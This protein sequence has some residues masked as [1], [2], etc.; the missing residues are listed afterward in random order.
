M[1]EKRASSVGALIIA[2]ALTLAGCKGDAGDDG[3]AGAAGTSCTV[4]Q[5]GNGTAT[6]SCADGTTATVA[7]GTNG[8][9]GLDG[10]SCTVKDNGNGTKTITCADGTTVTVADGAAGVSAAVASFHGGAA[11][12]SEGEFAPCAPGV[13]SGC[14]KRFVNA[15]VTGATADAAGVVTVQF[16]VSDKSGAPVA[17]IPSVGAAIVRLQPGVNGSASEWVPYI[18]R[19]Q[20]AAVPGANDDW[21]AANKPATEYQPNRES[22]GT[23]ASNGTLTNHGDGTYTYVFK[24]NLATAAKNGVLVG[25]DRTQTHRVSIMM[26]GH[27]GATADANFD[28]RPDG[29]AMT[30]R[31]DVVVTAPCLNC[32]GSEFHGHGGDRLTMENCVTCHVANTYDPHGGESLDMKVMIHKIHA[33][34]ELPS[35][36]NAAPGDYVYAIWGNSNTKHSWPIVE[37]PA[38]IE[39]CK[40]CHAGTHAQAAQWKTKPTRDACGSCHDD[41][42]FANGVNH[43]AQAD[44]AMCS[45]CHPA[46]SP[47][48]TVNP[49]AI[50]TAH[51]WTKDQAY[52]VDK[53]NFPEFGVELAI[54]NVPVRGYFVAGEAPVIVLKLRDL[55]ADGTPYLDHTTIVEDDAL[56]T[57]TATVCSPKDG[58]FRAAALMVHGPR[59]KRMPALTSAARAQILS[60][61]AGPWDLSAAGATLVLKVDNGQNVSAYKPTGG[62]FAMLGTITVPVSAAAFASPA[63]ATAPEIVAW[64]NANTTFAQRAIAFEQAGRVGIRSRNLGNVYALQLQASAVATA[65]FAGDVAVKVPGGNG[66]ANFSQRINA[67]NE[68]PKVVRT[69]EQVT[70]TLDPVDDAA[71]GTY[72]VSVE[73]SDR[74]RQDATVY[75]TPS[76]GWITFQVKQAAEE[77]LP[78]GNCSLC[79]QSAD[80]VG[81]VL[82]PSRHNKKFGFDAVDQCGPCHDQQRG[83]ITTA[84]WGGGK[85]IS[86]RVHAVHRGANL[87]YPLS[88]VDYDNGDPSGRDWQINYPQDIRN[89]ETCHPEGVTS[90]SWKTKPGRLPCMGCHDSDAATAHIKLNTWDPTP[91]DPFS[92]DEQ[93]AC[94]TCH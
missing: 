4:T 1:R 59:A 31:R 30:E 68:D 25:Y 35:V 43:F 9:N 66:A 14:G 42:D 3:T 69:A 77:K 44:D 36:H 54:E 91:A 61:G 87:N 34:R 89:C 2:G 39:N 83:G 19:A 29:Q 13:T 27:Q 49:L 73:I 24:T 17:N 21:P 76:V 88:T 55:E 72:V 38:V 84:A 53:R 60:S 52:K 10:T 28:F 74:G 26:G 94:K 85:P 40:A 90:G 32:H 7:N 58:K 6:I 63:A 41:L 48:G 37:F 5:N 33:G 75:R 46:D 79:H 71:P 64:L 22:S 67:A 93:E 82:D 23:G 47:A 45:L 65:V 8:Q 51:D 62:D 57:C 20:T 78:A 11:L 81:F 12:E 56:E 18:F 15:Q 50:S 16:R 86:K 80:G 92:G 70:Y